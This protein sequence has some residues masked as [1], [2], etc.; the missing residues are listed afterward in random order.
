MTKNWLTVLLW[1]DWDKIERVL[2]TFSQDSV[3]S[4]LFEN[5]VSWYCHVTNGYNVD[6]LMNISITTA[7]LFKKIRRNLP[8]TCVCPWFLSQSLWSSFFVYFTSLSSL[9]CRCIF[10]KKFTSTND[11][12]KKSSFILLLKILV[13]TILHFCSYL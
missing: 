4:Q 9:S 5:K 6:W 12:S 7:A 13:H 10:T 1:P 11:I 8:E 2:F 3:W